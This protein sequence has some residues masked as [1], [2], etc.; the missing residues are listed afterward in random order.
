MSQ[1][2]IDGFS[3]SVAALP[4]LPLPVLKFQPVIVI[5]RV[6]RSCQCLGNRNTLE[7]FDGG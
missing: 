2:V 1:D 5:F 6:F 7:L 3:Y 4:R